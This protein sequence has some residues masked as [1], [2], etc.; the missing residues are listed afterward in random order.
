LA[1]EAEV[2]ARCGATEDHRNAV[3]AFLDKRPARFT[4]H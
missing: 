1:K 2:Q 4:G 3:T